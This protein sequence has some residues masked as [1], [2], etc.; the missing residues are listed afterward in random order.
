MKSDFRDLKCENLLLSTSM[1][2]CQVK[3]GDF[4]FAVKK[5][6]DEQLQLTRCGSFA[7]TAPEIL[8]H[9]NYDGK[10]SDIWSL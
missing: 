1:R 2:S 5:K 7:Y 4:G 6:S 3:I 8:K 10:K 9:K